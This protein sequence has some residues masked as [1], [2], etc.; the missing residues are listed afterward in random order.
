MEKELGRINLVRL[1]EADAIELL[2]ATERGKILHS[3]NNI[4]ESGAP[5]EM[6]FRER[7]QSRLPSAYR[8]LTG[9]LFDMDSSCTPQ[10]DAMVIDADQCHEFM[11]SPEGGSYIP[12]VGALAIVEIK[13][14]LYDV[15]KCLDQIS[16]TL[17]SIEAMRTELVRRDSKKVDVPKPLSIAIFGESSC[18]KFSDF[19][20]AYL[21][22]TAQQLPTYT[23]LLDR[24]VVVAARSR[25]DELFE[26]DEAGTLGFG[27]HSNPGSPYVWVPDGKE[28][29]RGRA[30]LWLYLSILN[31]LSMST[32]R[33]AHLRAFVQA[34]EQTY[35]LR[36]AFD[37]KAGSDW[38]TPEG[39]ALK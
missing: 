26:S 36:H 38:P 23:V 6:S 24:G 32:S 7:L 29:V 3:T 8:V 35:R 15:E 4:R 37:L 14:S 22:K 30:L 16:H 34:A 17:N 27:D 28:H 18:C 11:T 2:S 9:Y 10:V 19:R 33:P 13:N 21:S 39:G 12:F 25:M 31:H 1:F 20:D 5:L